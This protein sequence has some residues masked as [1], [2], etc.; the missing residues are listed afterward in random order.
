M[1][2]RVRLLLCAIT[3]HDFKPIPN[4]S[5]YSQKALWEWATGETGVATL[6]AAVTNLHT[7]GTGRMVAFHWNE[8]AA[9]FV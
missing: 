4:T 1:A 5:H 8:A 3:L 6:A 2:E 9:E 7:G